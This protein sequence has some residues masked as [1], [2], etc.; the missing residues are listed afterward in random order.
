MLELNETKKALFTIGVG[1]FGKMSELI[2]DTDYLP[3]KPGY[4]FKL[5]KMAYSVNANKTEMATE[6][7]KDGKTVAALLNIPALAD[8][9]DRVSRKDVVNAVGKLETTM[10]QSSL[11]IDI[12]KKYQAALEERIEM[13]EHQEAWKHS[14]RAAIIAKAIAQWVNYREPEQAFMAA[15]LAD[16]PELVLEINDPESQEKIHDKVEKGLS[17]LEAEMVVLGFDHREFGAKLFKYFGMPAAMIDMAHQGYNSYKVKTQ[18]I[19]LTKITNFARFL[20]KCFADKTQSPSSIW[21]ES[22]SAIEGLGLKISSEEWGNK[23]SL[24]FVKSLEF[25]M[26]VT[27]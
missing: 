5:L 3:Q 9:Y 1:A 14:I 25:E 18:N 24:L 26:S 12:A 22:Q 6:I 23:I 4:F 15:L 11:E 21:T 13:P 17:P 7:A 2:K 19:L 20:A 8:K 10:I 27:Q 16:L